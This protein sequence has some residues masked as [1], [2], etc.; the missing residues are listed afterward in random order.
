MARAH[1]S[2]EIT[3]VSTM[4]SGASGSSYGRCSAAARGILPRSTDGSWWGLGRAGELRGSRNP[5]QWREL[6]WPV[7]ATWLC[8]LRV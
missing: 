8:N 3:D 7:C 6:S 2:A 4:R 1:S 5:D